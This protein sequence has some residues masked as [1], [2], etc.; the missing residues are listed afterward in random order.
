MSLVTSSQ[1]TDEHLVNFLLGRLPD[2]EAQRLDEA[3]I[4]DDEF[5]AHLR[6]VEHDLV[7]AYVS[8][9]LAGQQ[10]ERFESHYL[11]SPRR[12]EN[13]LFATGFLSAVERAAGAQPHSGHDRTLMFPI[14]R[15][16][17]R[18]SPSRPVARAPR[19]KITLGLAAAA[20][21]LVVACGALLFEVARLRSGLQVSQSQST[22][23]GQRLRDLEQ[24]L[25]TQAATQT[26]SA[27]RLEAAGDS[28]A[29]SVSRS[30]EPTQSVHMTALVLQPQTRAVGPVPTV[31]VSSGA[32]SVAFELQ[33]ESNEF[34]RYQVALNDPATNRVE[35]RSDP[36]AA[37]STGSVPSIP[38]IVPARGL[39]PHHYSLALVGLGASKSEVVG[40]YTFQVVRR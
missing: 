40:S 6:I 36:I 34:S 20:A 25:G 15:G 5:V 13:V 7:D 28:G 33:L 31:A 24:Q 9:A 8:G 29:A 1:R 37:P 22:E 27:G 12:R 17:P 14:D 38:V 32:D 39:K 30:P 23:Q 3:S 35:W 21:V 19:S 2:E 10:L 11:A 4:A 18:R 16:D 26:K